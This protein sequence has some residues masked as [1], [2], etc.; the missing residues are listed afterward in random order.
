MPKLFKIL[1]IF[2]DAV[3]FAREDFKLRPQFFIIETAG[4]LISITGALLIA[5][6]NEQTPFVLVWTLFT[7]GSFILMYVSYVRKFSNLL[8]LMLVYAVIDIVGLINS[9]LN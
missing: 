1:E 3:N 4:T 2:K 9:L 6:L 5:L 7:V 8:L